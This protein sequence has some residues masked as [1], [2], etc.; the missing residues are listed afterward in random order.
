MN[1]YDSSIKNCLNKLEEYKAKHLKI[2]QIGE[3]WEDTKD[4]NLVLK[5]EMAYELG[6]EGN[7]S[8]SGFAITNNSNIVSDDEIILYGPDLDEIKKDTSY[9][10]ITILYV[11]DT[12]FAKRER[13]YENIRKMEYTRYHLNPWGYM[14]RISVANQLENVRVSKEAIKNN[15]SFSKIGKLFI[16]KYKLHPQVEKVKIIFITLPEFPYSEISAYTNQ[17]EKITNSLDKIFNNLV[18]D[19]SAC[20]LKDVCEEVEGMRELHIGLS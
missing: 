5:S 16:D 7:T 14:M 3:A 13:A 2:N 10:R 11:S 6:G 12:E 1:L 8:I 15:I 17:M 4:Y 9:G 20:K 19:C 18:M